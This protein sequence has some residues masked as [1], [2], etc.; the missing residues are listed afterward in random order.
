MPHIPFYDPRKTYQEN[1]D[2]GPF[3]AFADGEVFAT[4]GEPRGN[5][6]GL[7]VF[8]PF[9]IAAGPLVNGKYVKAAFAKGFDIATYKTVRTRIHPSN[10]WPNVLPIESDR[11]A[12]G[13]VARTKQDYTGKFSVT[14]SFGVPSFN[15]DFWQKDMAEAAAAAG[16][17][18]VM[19]GSFQGTGGG[20]G[21]VQAYIDDF[22]LAARLV[23]ETGAKVLEVNLSC[24]N[25]GA[26]H[27]LCFDTERSGKVV[28]SIRDEIGNTPLIIKIA[29]FDNDE[30]LRKLISLVADK[31]SAVAAINAI[32]G[33]VVDT[34]GKQAL[35]ENRPISGVGGPAA[36]WAGLEMTERLRKI[37]QEHDYKFKIIGVGG[38]AAV[39]DYR[40]YVAAGADAVMSASGVMWNP[41]LAQEIKK[42]ML[43]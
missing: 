42:E 33:K 36:K 4:S 8:V 12:P 11:L 22:V 14:N 41:F 6:F 37:R 26:K 20:D 38:V 7:P 28:E 1:F 19:V 25:E 31:I 43:E 24:P 30:E 32:S 2:E 21:N 27:L 39:A 23:K 35:G 3:G 15:P 40:E 18:Q 17:G 10:P 16:T 9:G 5:F 29:Y 34:K 13:G